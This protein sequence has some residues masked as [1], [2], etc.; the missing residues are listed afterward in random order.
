MKSTRPVSVSNEITLA[1]GL[2][3]SRK[4]GRTPTKELRSHQ[5]ALSLCEVEGINVS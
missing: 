2:T 4:R 3:V 5:I 1:L